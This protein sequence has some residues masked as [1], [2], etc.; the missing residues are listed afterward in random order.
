VQSA[1]NHRILGA[2]DS[3]AERQLLIFDAGGMSSATGANLFAGLPGWPA[4]QLPPPSNCHSPQQWGNFAYWGRCRG[5]TLAFNAYLDRSGRRAAL[6]WWL[7]N[8][9]AHP[10]AYV[11]HRLAFTRELLVSEAD[12]GWRHHL[13]G[14][15]T[16]ERIHVLRR[17]AAGRLDEREVATWRENPV[18]LALAGYSSLIY[19]HRFTEAAAAAACV[20]LL[21]WSWSRV[22]RGLPLDIVVPAAAAIGLANLLVYIPF[23]IASWS[24]YLWPTVCCALFAF[25]VA[26]RTSE[27]TPST[28]G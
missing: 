27:R 7:G 26:L 20:I 5:Y 4:H 3:R 6:R 22:R 24:R 23:G 9:A 8:I 25:V 1:F 13:H 19:Q 21:G 18:A 2:Y 10:A 28:A 15:N 16:P 12:E 11:R 17:S 14:I